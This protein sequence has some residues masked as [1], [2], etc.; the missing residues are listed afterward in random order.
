MDSSP[1]GAVIEA[2]KDYVGKTPCSVRVWGDKD[3]TFHH[4]RTRYVELTAS[5]PGAVPQTKRFQ[6]G[7]AFSPKDTIPKHVFFEF[8]TTREPQ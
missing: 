2:D 6:T 8:G 1:Q 3:G 7:A 4:Y 5:L